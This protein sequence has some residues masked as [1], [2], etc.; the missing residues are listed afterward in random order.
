MPQRPTSL[1]SKEE[2]RNNDRDSDGLLARGSYKSEAEVWSN[3]P[4][5]KA[6]GRQGWRE[7]A[8]IYRANSC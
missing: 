8:T 1:K 3:T 4:L 7:E 5:C 2:P 6:G